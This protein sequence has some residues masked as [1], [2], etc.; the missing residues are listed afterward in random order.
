MDNK[1]ELYDSSTKHYLYCGGG[2]SENSSWDKLE[3]FSGQLS[4]KDGSLVVAYKDLGASYWTSENLGYVGDGSGQPV[5]FA[6]PGSIFIKRY[7]ASANSALRVD[8]GGSN[9]NFE[10]VNIGNTTAGDLFTMTIGKKYYPNTKSATYN[11]KPTEIT[12]GNV[13]VWNVGP[14]QLFVQVSM[15]ITPIGGDL[16]HITVDASNFEESDYAVPM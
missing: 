6:E 2:S 15:D 13:S 5:V 11:R 8:L 9:V 3:T 16:I 1:E 7:V 12:S 14:G 4:S 10:E